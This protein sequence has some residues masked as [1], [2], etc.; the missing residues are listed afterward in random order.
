MTTAVEEPQVEKK[1]K[2]PST[3]HFKVVPETRAMRDQVRAAA[4]EFGKTLD[5]SKPLTRP[6]LQSIG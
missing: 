4:A 3:A 6:V 1:E 2:R 5:R